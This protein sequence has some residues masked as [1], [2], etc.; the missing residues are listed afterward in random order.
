MIYSSMLFEVKH[1]E[2]LKIMQRR[3]IFL[4]V[5]YCSFPCAEFV[6]EQMS[7]SMYCP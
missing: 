4:Y 7:K 5:N 1:L 2:S 3:I 6:L